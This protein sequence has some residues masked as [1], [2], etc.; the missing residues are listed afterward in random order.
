ML[1][2]RHY[3]FCFHVTNIFHQCDSEGWAGDTNSHM[4]ISIFINGINLGLDYI[5][6]LGSGSFQRMD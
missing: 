4:K 5:L 3:S 6:I 1:S 2:N